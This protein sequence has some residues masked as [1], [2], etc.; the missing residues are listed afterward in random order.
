MKSE[1]RA[2]LANAIAIRLNE[3]RR[4]TPVENA[5]AATLIASAI[6][7]LTGVD[8]YYREATFD[9]L[10]DACRDVFNSIPVGYGLVGYGL[11]RRVARRV[12][13][14]QQSEPLA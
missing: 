3:E 12:T 13:Q 10:S 11:A 6:A 5:E 8:E 2:A 7:K 1:Q 9:E 14:E 4:N